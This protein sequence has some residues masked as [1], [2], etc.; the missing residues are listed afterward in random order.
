M[1]YSNS[2][3]LVLVKNSGVKYTVRVMNME[4]LGD[5]K[6]VPYLE[7]KMHICIQN[8]VGHYSKGSNV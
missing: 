1:L 5:I 4:H 8:H 6:S 3:R 2:W 7:V